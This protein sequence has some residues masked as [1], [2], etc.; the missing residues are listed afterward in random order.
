M[1]GDRPKTWR[2]VLLAFVVLVLLGAANPDLNAGTGSASPSSAMSTSVQASTAQSARSSVQAAKRPATG[3]KAA[4][5]KKGSSA[6]GKSAKKSSS[7]S[8]KKK[9]AASSEDASG[10]T[11]GGSD[12]D[13]DSGAALADMLVVRFV[14]VGQGDASLIE[15][16]DGKTMLIDAASSSEVLQQLRDDSRSQIDWLVA[17]HPDADHIG[18]LADI[19]SNYQVAS[20]WAP[21]VNSPTKTYTNFLTAI[22]NKGLGIEPCYAGRQIAAGEGYAIDLLWP[23]QGASYSAD[24]DYSAIIKVTYG[25]NTFLFT[26]DAPV[27]AQS[28]SVSGHVDVLKVS[29]HGSASGMDASLARKLTPTISVLSYGKNSYGHPT[30][31]VLDALKAVGSS[32]YGTYAH[33]TVTVTSDGNSVLASASKQGVIEAASKSSGRGSRRVRSS[34]SASGAAGTTSARQTDTQ[35]QATAPAA[36]T[37]T[38]DETVYIT[39]TGGKYHRR[40]CRTTSRSKSLTSLSKSQAQSSGYEA[41]AVCNP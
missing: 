38:A 35:A 34:A 24:N 30:Q 23:Q 28:Q 9:N 36:D 26:G 5:A 4:S 7:A 39:P 17:T 27:D 10:S 33:G 16:P 6:K 41:C 19:I 40:G 14:D 13:S 32:I 25:S 29:H 18:G 20:V 8:A 21:E 15:F 31:V 12:S 11:S 3:K 2:G 1:R 37:A 22:A